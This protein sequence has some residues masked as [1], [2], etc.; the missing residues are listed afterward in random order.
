M[1]RTA[2]LEFSRKK[3]PIAMVLTSR[4]RGYG[5]VSARLKERARGESCSLGIA[6]GKLLEVLKDVTLKSGKFYDYAG[7]YREVNIRSTR[8]LLSRRRRSSSSSSSSGIA[9]TT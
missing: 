3:N 2:H 8:V 1:T 6:R 9:K 4:D 5:I 7:K